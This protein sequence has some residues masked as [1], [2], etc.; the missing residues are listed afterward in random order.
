MRRQARTASARVHPEGPSH[1]IIGRILAPHG[2]DGEV[3]VENLSDF[4]QRFAGLELVYLGEE[5]APAVIERQRS[6]RRRILLKLKGCEDRDQAGR[7]R[8]KY[9]RVPV[10][11]AMALDEDEYYIHE[12]LGLEVWTG[13]GEFLGCVGE[14]L[15]T[16]SNDV[17]VVSNGEKELLIPAL[18]DVVK[19]I[20]LSAG[21]MT[22]ELM[23]GLS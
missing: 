12:V 14:I 22:V 9:I 4:P 20:D 18:S 8:G 13:E 1:L 2:V 5:L 15:F 23:R 10:E 16:G 6:K 17:Y 21:R 11:E 7:L 3:E 19:E